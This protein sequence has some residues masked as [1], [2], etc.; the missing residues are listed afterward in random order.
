MP[1]TVERILAM[2]LVQ[3]GPVPSTALSRVGAKKSY[4]ELGPGTLVQSG[5]MNRSGP[6]E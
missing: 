3:R 4:G 5:V 2:G 6:L 1:V